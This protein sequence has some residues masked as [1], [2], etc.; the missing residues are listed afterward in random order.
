MRR[1]QQYAQRMAEW[2]QIW[3]KVILF[4]GLV[5]NSLFLKFYSV[6]ENVQVRWI[7]IRMDQTEVEE[8][9]E[10]KSKASVSHQR[11]FPKLSR[12]GS[13]CKL[14]EGEMLGFDM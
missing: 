13:W 6:L 11:K 8:M 12:Y 5:L 1:S 3:A 9:Q 7:L 10:V 14:E 4:K 2:E